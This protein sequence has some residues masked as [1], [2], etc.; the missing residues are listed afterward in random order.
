MGGSVLR[1][2]I[3][4]PPLQFNPGPL[5]VHPTSLADLNTGKTQ[6]TS[7]ATLQFHW[8]TSTEAP[9]FIGLHLN[10]G[11]QFSNHLLRFFL[12]IYK[13]CR[14]A[15]AGDCKVAG[16]YRGGGGGGG[17]VATKKFVCLKIGLHFSTSLNEFH[18][19]PEAN[20]LMWWGGGLAKI[21][22]RPGSPP[23]QY[24]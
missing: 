6:F 23:P 10:L 16:P 19:S 13:C 20:F 2:C 1:M 24:H 9:K 14:S 11:D 4:V 17:L 21:P 7:A 15:L 8:T 3:V 22:G 12:L 5:W 18:F